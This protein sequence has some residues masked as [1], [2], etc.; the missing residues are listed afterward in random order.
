MKHS[1]GNEAIAWNEPPHTAKKE[2]R[3]T[4]TETCKQC[5]P[6]TFVLSAAC[7]RRHASFTTRDTTDVGDESTN[8]RVHHGSVPSTGRTTRRGEWR[9]ITHGQVHRSAYIITRRELVPLRSCGLLF[10]A[11][12][13]I[14]ICVFLVFFYF[15][16]KKRGRLQLSD[17]CRSDIFCWTS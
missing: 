14:C 5:P 9:P 10:F 2:R 7:R 8:E 16:A 3:K 4:C 6:S 15:L 17:C 11:Y 12:I 13:C 1:A